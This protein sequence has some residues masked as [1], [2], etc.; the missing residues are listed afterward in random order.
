MEV[1]NTPHYLRPHLVNC[2]EDLC[3]EL[4]NAASDVASHAIQTAPDAHPSCCSTIGKAQASD[5]SGADFL[6]A[7]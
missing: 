7:L 4:A 1:Y 6:K 5:P 2:F 3:S